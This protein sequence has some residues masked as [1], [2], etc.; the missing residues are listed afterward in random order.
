MAPDTGISGAGKIKENWENKLCDEGKTISSTC[1]V[2]LEATLKKLGDFGGKSYKEYDTGYKELVDTRDAAETKM[3][4]HVKGCSMC[5]SAVM[6]F[7]D[8][9][10]VTEEDWMCYPEAMINRTRFR[11]ASK[12]DFARAVEESSNNLDEHL[13]NGM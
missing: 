9:N 4:S 3:V 5:K 7:I 1:Q 11:P 13:G 8:E 2:A 12:E 6:A 10:K